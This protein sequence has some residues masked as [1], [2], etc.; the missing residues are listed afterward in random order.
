MAIV[1]SLFDAPTSP[2]LSTSADWINQ[3]M[4]GSLA[5]SLCVIAIALIGFMLMSGRL[6]VRDAIRVLL[7]CFI[8]LAAP[9]IA[10]DL[11][12]LMRNAAQSVPPQTPAIVDIPAPS[13]LP[14][15]NYAPYAGASLQTQ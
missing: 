3:T 10:S 15:S 7:G 8:L 9:N 14:Q 4:F 5:V 11:Q 13:T 2:V 1:T 12:A 6:I